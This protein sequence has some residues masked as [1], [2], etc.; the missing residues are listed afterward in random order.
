[1]FGQSKIPCWQTLSFAAIRRAN[2]CRFKLLQNSIYVSAV[3]GHN[4]S[5]GLVCMATVETADT[6][7]AEE[8]GVRRRDFI[9]IAA[10]SFAG[11]GAVATV[12]PLVNQMNPSADVLAL[13]S[14]DVDTGQG[15]ERLQAHPIRPMY[16]TDSSSRTFCEPYRL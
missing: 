2:H 15:Y 1:M 10:V 16:A 8:S 4:Y 5:I 11:A 7:V 9:N 6:A 14:V 12:L 3:G 13:A